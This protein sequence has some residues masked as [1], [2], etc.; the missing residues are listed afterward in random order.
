MDIP[1]QPG[2][3]VKTVRPPVRLGT[4]LAVIEPT[5]D[6]MGIP[7][8]LGSVMVTPAGKRYTSHMYFEEELDICR[9]ADRT[10]RRK[11][12]CVKSAPF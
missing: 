11:E 4:V 8:Q 7:T 2:D 10:P 1:F 6:A 9:C 5:Y 3:P 12:P